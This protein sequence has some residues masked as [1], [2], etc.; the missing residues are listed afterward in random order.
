MSGN[1]NQSKYRSTTISTTRLDNFPCLIL[2][3]IEMMYST[4][5]WGSSSSRGCYKVQ[6]ALL[7][8]GVVTV[9]VLQR[10]TVHLPPTRYAEEFA[11]H[12]KY[13]T[14]NIATKKC[15]FCQ[16]LQF[17]CA[18]QILFNITHARC[19]PRRTQ[20]FIKTHGTR[21][22]IFLCLYCSMRCLKTL[23]MFGLVSAFHAW[24]GF[25]TST[26]ITSEVTR[27]LDGISY[28]SSVHAFNLHTTLQHWFVLNFEPGSTCIPHCSIDSSWTSNPDHA[29]ANPEA[30]Q[31]VTS[32][33]N[34]VSCILHVR[35]SS[36][37]GQVSHTY[38]RQL[39]L[40]TSPTAKST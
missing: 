10:Y 6:H 21:N 33:T 7:C 16:N 15:G 30:G 9:C 3:G 27:Y 34:S 11:F 39:W 25:K 8:L 2:S 38:E 40:A 26:L 24:H 32:S 23:L 19:R 36:K 1:K 20:D 12:A 22:H 35:K 17:L 13:N 5:S 29:S 31:A 4:V 18:S 28:L 14:W 37:L